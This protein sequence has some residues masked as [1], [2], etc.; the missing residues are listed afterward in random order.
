MITLTEIFKND[1]ENYYSVNA[2]IRKNIDELLHKT[3]VIRYFYDK[4]MFVNSG[5]RNQVHNTQVG[6]ARKSLHM[7]GLAIDFSDPTHSI[8][9]FLI[10][11]NTGRELITK[12]DLYFEN[13][14]YTVTWCH[15]QLRK[16]GS[17]NRIFIP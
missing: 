9:N 8:Y 11:S 17:G 6:G 3:N 2:E 14:K 13:C 4:P 7:A 16:P 1:C 15:I 10:N 12:L 5:Y